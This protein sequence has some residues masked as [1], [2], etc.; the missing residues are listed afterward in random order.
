MIDPAPPCVRKAERRPDAELESL[1]DPVA[2]LTEQ[3]ALRDP[4]AFDKVIDALGD[5]VLG[6]LEDSIVVSLQKREQTSYFQMN[7]ISGRRFI[8]SIS[9][10]LKRSGIV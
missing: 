6:L 3:G 10:R 7:V 9:A 1:R 5:A 2:G 4:R 8:A